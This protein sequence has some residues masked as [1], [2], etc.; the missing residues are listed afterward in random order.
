MT[1]VYSAGNRVWR[2]RILLWLSYAFAVWF[3]LWGVDLYRTYGLRP[4]DGGVLAPEGVRLAWLAFMSLFG[5]GCAVGMWFYAR[6]YIAAV[7]VD[8]A[9]GQ[10][11]LRT[12]GG[13]W[14]GRIVAPQADVRAINFSHGEF[15]TSKMR[16][17]AP[18]YTLHVSGRPGSLI[19]DAQGA[20][21]DE[22]LFQ[23]IL[24]RKGSR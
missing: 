11:M 3:V 23:Q 16:V 4:A 7:W 1:L 24:Q 9:R 6:M 5:V 20:V 17:R 18:W 19:L 21:V 8:T 2:V 14:D 22:P 15:R 13:P 10:V 12:V